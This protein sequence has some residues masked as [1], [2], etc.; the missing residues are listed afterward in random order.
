MNPMSNKWYP[1]IGC[2]V[3]PDVI[4]VRELS[5]G[6]ALKLCEML[7]SAVL[8]A[9][10]PAEGKQVKPVAE[11]IRSAVMESEPV[12]EFVLK[13]AVPSLSLDQ[14]RELPASAAVVIVA[15]AIELTLNDEVLTAGNGLAARLKRA[16]GTTSASP[17]IS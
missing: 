15:S 4:E 17:S 11:L 12:V 16:L 2:K 8:V 3:G 9:A 7:G 10:T 14:L 5:W 13:N 1:V 6:N